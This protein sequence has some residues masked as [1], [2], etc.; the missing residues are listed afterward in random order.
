MMNNKKNHNTHLMTKARRVK[1]NTKE[2]KIRLNV[3]LRIT[4]L[5]FI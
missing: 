3:C 5:F 1:K 4:S 2:K